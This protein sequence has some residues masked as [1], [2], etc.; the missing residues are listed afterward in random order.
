M[1]LGHLLTARRRPEITLE[2]RYERR[3]AGERFAE[4]FARAFLIPASGLRRRFLDLERQRSHGVTQGDL[5][6][7]ARFFGVS[8]EVMTH[9]LEELRLIPGG[10]WERLRKEGFRVHEETPSDDEPFRPAT[11]PWPS[12]PGSGKS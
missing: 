9:R 8:V 12:K 1:S 3:P 7:L 2:A 4:A 6:R 11:S 5:Y 10:I